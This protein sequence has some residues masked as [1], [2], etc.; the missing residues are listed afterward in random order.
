MWSK[1][2]GHCRT[3]TWAGIGPGEPGLGQQPRTKGM[4]CGQGLVPRRA[5]STNAEVL[6]QCTGLTWS[7][8]AS[9]KASDPTS[10]GRSPPSRA[11]ASR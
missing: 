7:T 4:V 2:D 11:S 3:L 6:G 8:F 9:L 5:G 1:A 10:Q